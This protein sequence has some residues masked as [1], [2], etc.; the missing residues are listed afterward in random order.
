M[1]DVQA[2]TFSPDGSVVSC[3]G[4]MGSQ[5]LIHWDPATGTVLR[6]HLGPNQV[7]SVSYSPN[8]QWV[9][10][11]CPRE[12]IV[13]NARTGE[14]LHEFSHPAPAVS[15]VAFTP[16]NQTLAT[17]GGLT[18]RLWDVASGRQ[19]QVL[20]GHTD[21]VSAV[22]VSPDGTTVASAGYDREIR[23]WDTATGNLQ[24]VL[25]GHSGA[26]TRLF[27]ARDGRLIS[28]GADG[29]VR[30]WR[31]EAGKLLVTFTVL[32]PS[33]EGDISTRWLITTPEGGFI[34]DDVNRFVRWRVG[35][36]LYP[37]S[38]FAGRFR[39]KSQITQSLGGAAP[40]VTN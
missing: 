38:K 1:S 30:F 14:A 28:S 20:T 27:Y 24:R 13:W 3:G 11:G 33:D 7:Y 31:P 23:L 29:S 15:A 18:V 9:A 40:V 17:A 12:A 5:P 35:D 19:K 26:V 8:G 10:A 39:K 16:D 32:P 6:R 34:G 37:A 25:D 22:A 2:L 36:K 4:R 21:Q